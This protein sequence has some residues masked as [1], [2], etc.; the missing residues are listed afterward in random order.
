MNNIFMLGASSDIAASLAE[1]FLKRGDHVL[2]TFRQRTASL[3]HLE[4]S[5]VNLV[6]VDIASAESVQAL[7]TSVAQK[8]YKWNIFISAVGLLDPIGPFFS[9][10]FDAWEKSVEVNFTA[11]LRVLHAL[12][13]LRD[14]ARPCKIILFAG[15]GTNNPFDNYSAYCLGKLALIKMC[16]LLDSEYKNIQI[17]IIGTGW[18]NTK[19][20]Q[21]TLSAGGMAGVNFD[22]TQEF[23]REPEN[24]GATLEDVGE[25]IDWCLAAPRE[26]VSGRNFSVIHDPWR[27]PDF[28]RQ[29]QSDPDLCKLRRKQNQA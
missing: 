5:G 27:S 14:T 11:Q 17:S 21:Q 13:S 28:L 19:I 3:A 26:A 16:E 24:K 10:D 29:L 15:G 20:H 12:Y 18:V 4:K 1:R 6:P 7:A 25:C 2:G 9:L 22:K 23:I 8:K